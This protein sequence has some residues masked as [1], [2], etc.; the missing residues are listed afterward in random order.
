[1]SVIQTKG[2][3]ALEM[4]LKIL[5]HMIHCIVC[6]SFEYFDC[7]GLQGDRCE[8]FNGK[9]KDA[10]NLNRG[11]RFEIHPNVKEDQEG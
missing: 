3:E 1:M 4:S 11:L 6:Y 8:C 2:G 10:M 9:V 5:P 7:S